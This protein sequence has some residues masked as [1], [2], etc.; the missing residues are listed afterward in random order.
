MPKVSTVVIESDVDSPSGYSLVWE[1]YRE[2]FGTP[3]SIERFRPIKSFRFVCMH[4]DFVA[5]QEH[6]GSHPYWYGFKRV[7]RR[8][9]KQYLGRHH[10]LTLHRLEEAAACLSAR[11]YPMPGRR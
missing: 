10:R 5:R 8:I 9:Y 2:H 11:C 7:G 6:R 1:G 3:T 4:G